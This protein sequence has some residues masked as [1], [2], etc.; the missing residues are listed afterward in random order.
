MEE[1]GNGQRAQEG[2]SIRRTSITTS[3]TAT[4]GISGL[5]DISSILKVKRAE[6]EAEEAE[7]AN[8]SNGGQHQG[9]RRTSVA[10]SDMPGGGGAK[11]SESNDKSTPRQ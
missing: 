11:Q 3:S 1:N 5:T 6:K 4:T 8:L 2:S 10:F 7:K 9:P